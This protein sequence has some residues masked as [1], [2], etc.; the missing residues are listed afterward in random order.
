MLARGIN[1]AEIIGIWTQSQEDQIH[2]TCGFD[3]L[4]GVDPRVWSL[5]VELIIFFGYDSPINDHI[6]EFEIT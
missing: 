4:G 3:L 6:A 1:F 5:A 2:L